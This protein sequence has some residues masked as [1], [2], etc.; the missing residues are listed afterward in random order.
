MLFN[1]ES[2]IR[3]NE[4]VVAIT[5]ELLLLLLEHDVV[6]ITSKISDGK[7]A[8]VDACVNTLIGISWLSLS[9][10]FMCNNLSMTYICSQGQ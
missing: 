4:N 6:A 9:A 2:N 1:I 3:M 8:S 7:T 10:C 5:I